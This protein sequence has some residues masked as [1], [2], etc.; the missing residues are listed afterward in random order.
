M[1]VTFFCSFNLNCLLYCVYARV[2]EER[3]N[4]CGAIGVILLVMEYR[5]FMQKNKMKKTKYK[6]SLSY[7]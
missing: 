4:D 3:E 5:K 7:P 6:K 2:K 1:F